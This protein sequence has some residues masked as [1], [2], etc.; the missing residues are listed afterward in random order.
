MDMIEVLDRIGGMAAEWNRA[1]H[2]GV[3]KDGRDPLTP[4]ESAKSIRA[5]DRFNELFNEVSADAEVLRRVM[6][7]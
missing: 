4:E 3:V 1:R 5:L 2:M 7:G 6:G